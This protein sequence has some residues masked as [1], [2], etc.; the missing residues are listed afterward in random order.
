M[1]IQNWSTLG[2]TGWISLESK[3][4]WRV[5]SNTT[6]Q[7]RQFFGPQ[8]SLLSNSYI[9]TWL[10]DK[11]IALTRRTF[12]GKVMSLLF[13]KLSRLVITFLS[14]SKCLFKFHGCTHHLQWFWSPP[15]VKSVTIQQTWE[16]WYLTKLNYALGIS[17]LKPCAYL[18]EYLSTLGILHKTR[19]F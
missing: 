3:G 18:G 1:N 19:L 7:K 13:N 17:M 4:L 10:L 15:K 9:H 2:W 11:N 5:F 8:L 14:R 16:F 12:F 6:V